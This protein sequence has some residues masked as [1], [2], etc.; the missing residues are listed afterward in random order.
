MDQVLASG[1]NA[2]SI[3]VRNLDAGHY[4]IRMKVQGEDYFTRRFL[5]VKL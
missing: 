5:K 4:F 1:R 3:D 2:L